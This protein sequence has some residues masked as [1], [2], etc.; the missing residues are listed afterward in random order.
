VVPEHRVETARELATPWPRAIVTS[1]GPT[2][3]DSVARGL[4]HVGDATRVVVHDAARP[5]IDAG[6]IGRVIG[7][8][9]D[10]DGALPAQP[11]E[12]TLKVVDG[13]RVVETIDRTRLWRA[14]TPQ[15]F[16]TTALRRAHE[17]SAD[18]S[19]TDDAQLI[20]L[21][22]GRVAVVKGDRRNVK[23]TF[24]EDFELAEAMLRTE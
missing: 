13:D 5:F 10:H 14:Q 24:D 15:A 2:R 3:Q 7:A 17:R 20:E 4:E 19:A 21:A 8:L 6:L 22:G 23:I 11:V 9:D 1:G 16:V 18:A 12:E